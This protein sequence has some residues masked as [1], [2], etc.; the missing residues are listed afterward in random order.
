MN[1]RA[2]HGADR[3][4]SDPAPSPL[5]SVVLIAL[6]LENLCP[7][8]Q[9]QGVMYRITGKNFTFSASMDPNYSWEDIHKITRQ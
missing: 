6:S 8:H 4:D 7:V 2:R 9:V 3:A 5:Q 1:G